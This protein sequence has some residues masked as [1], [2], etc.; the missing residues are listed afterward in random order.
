MPRGS[1]GYSQVKKDIKLGKDKGETPVK[2]FVKKEFDVTLK[3][4]PARAKGWDLEVASKEDLRRRFVKRYGSTFEVKRD[5]VS[6]KTG[7]FYFEVWSHITAG[8]TGCMYHSK[9]DTLILVRKKEFIFLDRAAF[10]RWITEELYFD[11]KMSAGWKKLSTE[12]PKKLSMRSVGIS[13]NARGILIP[14]ADIK[15]S[16]ACIGVFKR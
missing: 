1:S 4:S 8:N 2:K 3:F 9:A 5:F 10:L 7:N 13:P 11:S 15:E 6:D 16:D 14:M 12:K